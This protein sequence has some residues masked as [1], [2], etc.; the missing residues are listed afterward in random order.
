MGLK[1]LVPAETWIGL[2]HE[3]V[4]RFAR[5]AELYIRPMYWA[6]EGAPGGVRPDPESTGV[7]A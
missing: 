3:G 2:V 4:K 1:P 6:E 7:S 5:D